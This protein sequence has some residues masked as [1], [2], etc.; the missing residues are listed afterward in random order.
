MKKTLVIT[1]GLP[2]SGKSSAVIKHAVELDIPPDWAGQPL[3]AIESAD[4]YWGDP[5][6]F[7]PEK[8]SEAHLYCRLN[9]LVAMKHQTKFVYVDNTNIKKKDYQVY[10]DLAKEHGYNCLFLESS[11]PWAWDVDECTRR[12]VHK[13]PKETIQ[14]MRDSF[15]PDDRFPTIRVPYESKGSGGVLNSDNGYTEREGEVGRASGNKGC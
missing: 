5:Y 1:R 11:T 12:C 9:T 10:L 3:R 2:G 15:E 4:A 6:N 13:V 8:L 7:V 14:R